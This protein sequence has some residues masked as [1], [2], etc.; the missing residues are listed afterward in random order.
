MAEKIK[1]IF[2]GTG[3]SIPTV[4]RNHPAVLL[5]YGH[6]NI[7]VD[8]GEGT[9]RQLRKAK[10]SPSKITRILVSHWHGDHILGLPGLLQ[11]LN[12]NGYN[13]DLIIYGPKGSKKQFQDLV[14]PHLGFYWK[15]SRQSGC[16]FNIVVEEVGSGIVFE[17]DDFSIESEEMDHDCPV[18]GYS[19]VVKEKT[20]LDKSKLEKLKIPNSPL[21]GKLVEGKTVE[22]NGKKVDGKKMIY[23]DPQ[24]K[25]AFIMDTR[26]CTGAVS[27]AKGADVLVSEATY[28]KEEA[29]IAD[30]YGHLTSVGAADIAK[31]AKVNA[32]VLIHLS[33]RYEAIPKVILEEAQSVFKDVII[34]EDLDGLEF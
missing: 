17:G 32:L 26:E 33:Q 34:P 4:R 18:V 23:K 28:S 31:K 27:L 25:V 5:N 2:L 8:C 3:S 21:L 15:I 12:L 16:N 11:T 24:R 7:L 13:R 6:E 22:I 20:R 9:Q 14:A 1:L 19:F 29:E 30:E 10:I